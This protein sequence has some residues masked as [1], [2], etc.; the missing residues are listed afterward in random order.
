MKA[1]LL[2]I[3][4]LTTAIGDFV[5]GTLYSTIYK[6]MDRATTMHVSASLML[7]N[8]CVFFVVVKWWER[9][10]LEKDQIGSNQ[11]NTRVDHDVEGHVNSKQR[12]TLHTE[13]EMT[14]QHLSL[15]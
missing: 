14:T 6:T 9:C 5:G 7:L 2:S 15:S 8:L 13:V 10:E 4:L 11:T 1:F 3:Y 12:N